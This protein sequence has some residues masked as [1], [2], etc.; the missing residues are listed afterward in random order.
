VDPVT[1]TSEYQRLEDRARTQSQ[2]GGGGRGGRG[3]EKDGDDFRLGALGSG[4]DY[5]PFIHHLGIATLAMSYGGDG[6]GGVYHSIYDDPTWYT[7]FSDGDFT[8]G[9]VFAQTFTTTVLRLADADVLPLRFVNLSQTLES[10]AQDVQALAKRTPNAPPNFDFSPLDNA[11]RTLSQAAAEYDDAFAAASQDGSLFKKNK[12]ELGSLNLTLMQSERK[13]LSET[14]LPRRSW[15]EHAFYA[16]GFYTGYAAKTLPGVR[17]AI[18]AGNW[19]E[20]ADQQKVL[21]NVI[22][23]LTTQI[24]NAR[25][26]LR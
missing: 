21:V 10:Y 12:D 26:R 25:A 20:A 1:N 8:Y 9:R 19:S 15:F 6:G 13:M 14:G 11:L 2:S 22:G 23:N 17:E 18:E 5:T 7:R 16:P 24:R 4:S 3:G